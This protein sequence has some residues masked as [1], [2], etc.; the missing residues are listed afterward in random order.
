MF[1]KKI[2]NMVKDTMWEC[3]RHLNQLKKEKFAEERIWL[4]EPVEFL[5]HFWYPSTPTNNGTK[6]YSDYEKKANRIFASRSKMKENITI[7]SWGNLRKVVAV[8]G[9][10]KDNKQKWKILTCNEG[11]AKKGGVVV[12]SWNHCG[13]AK[14]LS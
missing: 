1:R 2:M 11:Q 7:S 5:W 6:E 4:K 8:G 13:I 9:G 14:Q 10:N 3:K 12:K